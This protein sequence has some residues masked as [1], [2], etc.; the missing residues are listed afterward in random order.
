MNKFPKA[1]SN[2]HVAAHSLAFCMK[3]RVFK[4][5]TKIGK[6]ILLV[7]TLLS[8]RQKKGEFFSNFVSFLKSRFFK[9]A[10]KFD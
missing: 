6:D 3:L 2:F 10:T 8:K 7:L 4:K 5:A 9:K 1:D